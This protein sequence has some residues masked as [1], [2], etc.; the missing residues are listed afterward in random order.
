MK[1][2]SNNL[3]NNRLEDIPVATTLPLS[4]RRQKYAFPDLP[5][6]QSRMVT[7]RSRYI[8]ETLKRCSSQ[9]KVD[10]L[11]VTPC[12]ITSCSIMHDMRDLWHEPWFSCAPMKLNEVSIRVSTKWKR[13]LG[14]KYVQYSK[15]RYDRR[16]FQIFIVLWFS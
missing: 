10:W 2:F 9:S 8:D 11:A 6:T 14:S 3:C 4:S 15:E 12:S 7:I 13:D 5:T 1:C 16:R